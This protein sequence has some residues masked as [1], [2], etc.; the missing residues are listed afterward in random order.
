MILIGGPTATFTVLVWFFPSRLR[1]F[2]IRW[3]EMWPIPPL[4]LFRSLKEAEIEYLETDQWLWGARIACP[5]FLILVCLD[6]ISMG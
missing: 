5:L 2:M 6:A 1:A 3:A 4:G